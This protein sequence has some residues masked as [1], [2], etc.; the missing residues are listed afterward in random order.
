MDSVELF[1]NDDD[2]GVQTEVC[3]F[4]LGE[5]A[6]AAA[7]QSQARAFGLQTKDYSDQAPAA[8]PE[9]GSS[10]QAPTPERHGDETKIVVFDFP[11]ESDDILI[12][13]MTQSK[14]CCCLPHLSDEFK[15]C[16]RNASEDALAFDA[17][18]YA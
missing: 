8:G 6:R 5:E 9:S 4:L 12:I 1:G 11:V 2:S 7:R 14:L 3:R 15:V 10:T 13:S 16:L 17:Q 18:C